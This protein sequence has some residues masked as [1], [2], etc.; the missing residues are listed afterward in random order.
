ME[1]QFAWACVIILVICGLGLKFTSGF[2]DANS[3]AFIT[4]A[5]ALVAHIRI[6]DLER[7]K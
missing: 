1:A 6:G 2:T 3:N 5:V 7:R 4:M